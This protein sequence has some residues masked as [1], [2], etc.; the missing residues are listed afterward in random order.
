M[1]RVAAAVPEASPAAPT[2]L[3]LP[4]CHRECSALP[5]ALLPLPAPQPPGDPLEKPPRV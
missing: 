2:L 3:G 1:E 5:V 4:A